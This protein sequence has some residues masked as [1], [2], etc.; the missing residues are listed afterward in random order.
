MSNRPKTILG[1]AGFYTVL[2]LCL[3]VVGVGAYFLLFRSGGDNLP[4][5]ASGQE[6]VSA[7]APE[8]QEPDVEAVSPA[9]ISREEPAKKTQAETPAMPEE[10]V[11]DTPVVAEAPNLVVSPLN[12]DVVAAFSMDQLQ[13]SKTLED[14]R[15]H[16]GIDIA[17]AEGT[18]VLAA[19]AGK[20]LSVTD[21]ALMGT[22]VVLS[23]AGGYQTTYANLEAK[24]V[25]SKGDTVSAGQVLGAVGTTSIAEAAEG[26][27]L[28]FAVTKD[29]K[30]VDPNEYLKRK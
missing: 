13:Y 17:A 10:K 14:W 24:P 27:H 29:G 18:K 25:V 4:A 6:A 2:F 15:T 8:V 28:H 19:C 21:D 3:A 12:G 11:D 7:E 20:V 26:P 30:P 22:T 9:G 16:N 23:H 5:D 1:G